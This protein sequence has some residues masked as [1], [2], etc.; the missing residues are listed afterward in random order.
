MHRLYRPSNLHNV[1]PES[2]LRNDRRLRLQSTLVESRW[3]RLQMHVEKG[4]GVWVICIGHYQSC[5]RNERK[6]Y[7]V[8]ATNIQLSLKARVVKASLTLTMLGCLIF[9][10]VSMTLKAAWFVNL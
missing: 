3:L 7:G 4:L 6:T 5:T 10:N 2:P 8:D 9:E 1:R